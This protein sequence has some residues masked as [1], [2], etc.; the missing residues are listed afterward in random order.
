MAGVRF[1]FDLFR[2]DIAVCVGLFILVSLIPSQAFAEGSYTLS[3]FTGNFADAPRPE[4]KHDD[5]K[6]DDPFSAT[7]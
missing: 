3:E 4:E 2:L 7:W 1:L 5:D 6:D